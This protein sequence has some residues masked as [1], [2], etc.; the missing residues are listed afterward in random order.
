MNNVQ[1][2]QQPITPSAC[3]KPIELYIFIDPLCPEAYAMQMTLRKLQIEYGHYFTCRYVL[4]TELSALNCMTNR[5]K[6]CVTGAE[7]DITH[8]ALP[9]I[10][11]KAAELQGKRAGF[12]YLNKVQEVAALKTRNINSHATLLAIAQ[13]VNLD[14]NEFTTDFG[15]KE[16]ARAFQ[17]DLYLTREMEVEQIP[18]IVFFNECIEDE[19]LK[20]GGS[21]NYE[22]YE[23]ILRE[24]LDE[25][26]IR[27]PLPGL[28]ELFDRFS[29]M[30][31]AEV[32]EIYS[33][34]EQ[35][36]ERELKK[37]MLQQKVERVMTDDLT[38]WRAKSTET[39]RASNMSV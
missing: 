34:N 15:S 4:S 30:T 36:A 17:G 22:V 11:I 19:G 18:S 38:L 28:D 29:T 8:P 5:M 35:A 1:L 20:V 37:R 23:H 2:L 10:A 12:R 3:N 27:Q 21:Y 6:G 33:I 39:N 7:L 32:A 13:H 31:T 24:L 14:M 9:S 25:E 16:A 26:L